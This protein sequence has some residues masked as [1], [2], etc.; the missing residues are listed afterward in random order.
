MGR[1]PSADLG[2]ISEGNH[3]VL[4]FNLQCHN[5][6]DKDLEIGNPAERPDLFVP[7]DV[8]GWQFKEKFYTFRLKNDTGIKKEGHKVAFCLMDQ[9]RFSCD[10][11]GISAGSYDLYSSALPCQFIEVDGIGDGKYMLEATANA[12]SVQAAKTGK[13]KVLIEEDNYDDNTTSVQLQITGDK[14]QKL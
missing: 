1:D 10:N 11:Q 5:I 7:S 8:F 2:C 9:I 12:Y 3:R 13:G 6:G 4:R 14:V